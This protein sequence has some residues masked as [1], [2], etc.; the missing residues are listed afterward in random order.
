MVISTIQKSQKENKDSTKH[1][2]SYC[3]MAVSK[4]ES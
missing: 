3:I 1:V 2:S 4:L